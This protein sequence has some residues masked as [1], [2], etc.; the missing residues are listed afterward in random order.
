MFE[1]ITVLATHSA[2]KIL[3][4]FPTEGI[5]YPF[6]GWFG[7]RRICSTKSLREEENIALYDQPTIPALVRVSN[8]NLSLVGKYTGI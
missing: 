8:Q 3:G 5:R 1:C 6:S 7:E 2:D 4:V